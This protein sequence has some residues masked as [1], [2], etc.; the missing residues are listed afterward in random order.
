[1]LEGLIEVHVFP[2]KATAWILAFIYNENGALADP[3]A[4]KVTVIDPAGTT[5]LDKGAMTKYESTTGIYE[6]FYHKGEA[7]AVMDSGEWRGE[8]LTIDGSGVDAVVSSKPFAFT[9]T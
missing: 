8:I 5:K 9:V 1:M 7:S 6:Y 3:T 2:N 4:V